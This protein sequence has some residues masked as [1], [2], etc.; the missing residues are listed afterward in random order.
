[1][2]HFVLSL[3]VIF[4]FNSQ[5]SCIQQNYYWRECTGSVLKDAIP[6]GKDING[7]SIYFGQAYVKNQGLILASIY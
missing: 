6:A 3:V 2:Y 5:V 7:Q 4:F 1:M